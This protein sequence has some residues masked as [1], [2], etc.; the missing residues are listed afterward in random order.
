MPAFL[1]VRL[2]RI[3]PLIVVLG[4]VAVAVYFLVSW[5]HTPT[6]AKHA[7]IKVFTILGIGLTGFFGVATLYALLDSNMFVAEFFL[8][9]AAFMAILLGIT[10]ICRKIFLKRH[11]NFK[12]RLTP[13]VKDAS[14]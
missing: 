9:C 10:L 13:Q 11:Q 6:H 4:I 1:L 7:L 3:L 8:V 2:Y 12:W 14:K 5:R